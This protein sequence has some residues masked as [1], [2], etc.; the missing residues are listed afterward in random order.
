MQNDNDKNNQPT[1]T[2][3]PPSD[4][5][6]DKKELFSRLFKVQYPMAQDEPSEPQEIQ[7]DATNTDHENKENKEI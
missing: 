6:V 2:S 1:N 5:A 7:R 3:V 4:K